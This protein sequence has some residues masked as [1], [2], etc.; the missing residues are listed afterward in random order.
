MDHI[1]ALAHLFSTGQGVIVERSPFS[2]FV[3]NEALFRC[4]CITKESYN[5]IQ[6]SYVSGNFNLYRP[7]LVIYLDVP[8]EQTLVSS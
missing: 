8:V 5:G 2:D 7:H 6:E 1:D 3:F 4:G